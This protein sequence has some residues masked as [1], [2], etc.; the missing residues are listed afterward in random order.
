MNSVRHEYSMRL[1]MRRVFPHETHHRIVDE[2]LGCLEFREGIIMFKHSAL[3]V[4]EF[5]AFGFWLT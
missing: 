5:W 2:P 4:G 3:M 1:F